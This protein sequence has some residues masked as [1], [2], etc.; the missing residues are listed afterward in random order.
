LETG[1]LLNGSVFSYIYNTV[2]FQSNVNTFEKEMD[3]LP[4]Q[5]KRLKHELELADRND[6]IATKKLNEWLQRIEKAIL[7]V[8]SMQEGMLANK[9]N[10]CTCLRQYKLGRKVGKILKEVERLQK[11]GSFHAGMVISNHQASTTR[12]IPGP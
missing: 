9:T 8:N 6:K 12:H 4:D 1:R 3:N 10:L 5:R 2:R 7:E 11:A